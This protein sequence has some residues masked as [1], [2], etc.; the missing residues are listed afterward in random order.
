MIIFKKVLISDCALL[1]P[2]I[3]TYFNE[4]GISSNPN[5]HFP[6]LVFPWYYLP[7][8]C[9]LDQSWTLYIRKFIIQISAVPFYPIS[10]KK[11]VFSFCTCQ[12][13]LIE[14]LQEYSWTNYSIS[15]CKLLFAE[16]F[17]PW[18]IVANCQWSS[19]LS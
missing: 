16:I 6:F 1:D 14:Y 8:L 11:I 15:D 19:V 4:F 12:A 5:Y 3:L 17:F 2:P 13:C 18:M 9:F 7:F 10:V